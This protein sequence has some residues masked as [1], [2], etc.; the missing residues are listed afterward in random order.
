MMITSLY[1]MAEMDLQGFRDKCVEAGI[2]DILLYIGGILG[3]G[4]RVFEEDEA[5]FKKLGFDRVYP[6][7]SDVKKSIRD[8][9]DDL[10]KRGKI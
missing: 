8:L 6:P 2:G 10:R 1:G 5:S 9:C 4:T 7:E 3:V